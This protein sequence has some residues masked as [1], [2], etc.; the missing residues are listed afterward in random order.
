MRNRIVA[1]AAMLALVSCGNKKSEVC[2]MQKKVDEFAPVELKADISNLSEKEKQMLPLLFEAADIMDQLYWEQ[3]YGNKE[4]L[5]SK[6]SDEATKEFIM[7]NYGPWERLND[8]KPF[9][10]GYGEKPLGANF[11]PKDM[12]KEEFEA[13]DSPDK[14]SLYTLIVRNDEGNLESVPY[15]VAYK[16]KIDKA[17]ELLRKAAEL[18][19][20]EGLK[21]YLTLRAD[22]LQTDEYLESDLA[23]MDMKTNKIDFVVGPIENYED[24]L[25]N[26]KAA[27]EAYILIK[28]LDWT[29]KINRFAALLPKLQESLPVDPEYKKE[30]PGIDSDLGVYEVAYYAGDCNA[31]SKTIAINLPNDPRVH[32]EKGSRK[33]QLK[34]AMK[35]K[36]DKILLPIGNIL[37]DESQRQHIKFDAFFENVMFHEVGH[38]LGIKNLVNG[39]GTVHEALKEMHSALEEGKADILG[40]YMVSQLAKMGELP[41][42]DMMDNYVTFVA[43]IFRSVRFGAASSHGKA[44]M[45]CFN[46]LKDKGAFERNP[47]TG[48]YKVNFDKMT[49]A[50]NSLAHDILVLQGNGDYE[51]V[52]KW[53]ADKGFV[54]EELQADLNRISKADIPRD[55]RCIQGRDVLGL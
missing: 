18:A 31:G 3:A 53:F 34:N 24:A 9:V 15:H 16:E 45:V 5:L 38:G 48:T 46:Y 4:E 25:F 35:A 10:E 2:D 19:E 51:G 44:N 52:K 7:I 42:K 22:A 37:I 54:T 49:E 29:E 12:T 26:Y 41:E 30:K 14:T 43:G 11:Y 6:V 27:Y 40:L 21:K 8:N 28:D 47:E 36:F 50:M 33:L 17:A 55:I 1:F 23:W 13:F 39:E 32:L 20:D